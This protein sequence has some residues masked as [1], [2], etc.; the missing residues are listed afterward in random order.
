MVRYAKSRGV[1]AVVWYVASV[2][3]DPAAGLDAIVRRELL[4]ML[5][6]AIA[7]DGCRTCGC[8]ED[9]VCEDD[10]DCLTGEECRDGVFFSIKPTDINPLS[11][12]APEPGL[13]A[14]GKLVNGAVEFLKKV[15]ASEH[16]LQIPGDK[17]VFEPEII[18]SLPGDSC[19]M[20]ALDLFDHTVVKTFAKSPGDPLP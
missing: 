11:L 19:R 14:F 12:H 10:G 1:G 20:Q 4:E 9:A 17:A 15:V 3:D 6:G 16:T 2:L 7:D 8:Q 18:E 13:L 5:V